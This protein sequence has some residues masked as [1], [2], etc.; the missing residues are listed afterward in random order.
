MA[1]RSIL[2]T[3]RCSSQTRIRP[4]KP[5]A[6]PR[7]AVR[8]VPRGTR[9]PRVVVDGLPNGRHNTNGLVVHKGRLLIANGNST[10]DG[11]DGGPPEEPLSGTLLSLPVNARGLHPPSPSIAVVARGMRNDYD[12]AIRPGTDEAW[13]TMN[14]P[15]AEEPFGE[16][17]LLRA[18]L[19]GL[20]EDFG[21]PG[22]V[23]VSDPLRVVQ[24][25]NSRVADNCDGTETPPATLLGLHTSADGIAFGAGGAWG[26][27]AYV[28]MYGSNP[29]EQS[30]GRRV[31]RVPIGAGGTVTGPSR[32]IRSGGNPLDLTFGPAGLYVG[33]FTGTIFLLRAP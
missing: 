19:G 12:V 5:G 30:A 27:D 24:N 2:P 28:A 10:D 17:L 21:F 6:P 22:C 9:L 3:A 1:S 8:A 31:V 4:P 7:D 14:G 25:R 13:I 11:V 15:D 33:D 16:D 23:Y 32:T 20:V 29:G 26:G 18:P